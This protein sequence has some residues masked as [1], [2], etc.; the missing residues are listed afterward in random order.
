MANEMAVL[1]SDVLEERGEERKPAESK[2]FKLVTWN[3]YGLDPNKCYE[4]TIAVCEKVRE[5]KPDVLFFQE[6][7][8]MTWDTLT[9]YLT[10]YQH[11]CKSNQLRYF[12]T[13][14]IHKDS[15]QL[16]GNAAVT[17]FPGTRMLRHLL[18]CQVKFN[19]LLI[20]LFTSHLESMPED[21]PERKRQL[22]QAFSQM[23]SLRDKGEISIFGGD[24]NISSNQEVTDVGV[25]DK[26]VDLWEACGSPKR[27]KYT[28]NVGNSDNP[29]PLLR[30][31]RLY[32]CPADDQKIKP[33]K[34]YL[35]GTEKIVNIGRYPSDHFGIY[36][37]FMCQPGK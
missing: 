11:F 15:L 35:I 3:I 9:S 24:L 16:V 22:Q 8:P 7:I 4:R 6:V 26:I 21:A 29:Q 14:S 37:E 25:P 34:F 5:I 31:D 27:H 20:H 10:E 18:H 32:L 36:T 23:A 17:D 33:Q 19:G 12:H 2:T 1:Q 30:L 13:I 28:W